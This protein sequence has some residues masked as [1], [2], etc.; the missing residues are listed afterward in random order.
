[1]NCEFIQTCPIYNHLRTEGLRTYYTENF[2]KK[3][4]ERCR[5][6]ALR[7]SGKPVPKELLPDGRALTP[8]HFKQ[9]ML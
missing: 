2:C 9:S 5:R 4:G 6:K 1:M 3:S 7:A 8:Y